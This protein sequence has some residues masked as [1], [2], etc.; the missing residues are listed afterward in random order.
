[1]MDF[2]SRKSLVE[3]LRAQMLDVSD[4]EHRARSRRQIEKGIIRIYEFQT[5]SE[6][7][8]RDVKF[9]NG[10]GFTPADAY[11][12]SSFAV[13]LINNPNYHLSEKQMR[14]AYRRMPKYAGQLINHSINSGKIS[15]ENSSY[16][17]KKDSIS[18]KDK[19]GNTHQMLNI[20]ST[21]PK[22]DWEEEWPNAK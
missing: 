5:A 9:N 6:H 7:H 12:L 8:D 1:M 2:K 11:I 16:T 14:I 3:T 10:V 18:Y 4:E 17:W 20:P 15:K 21:D 22:N 13:Q 19:S